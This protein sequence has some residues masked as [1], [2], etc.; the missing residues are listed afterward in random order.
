MQKV[1]E[2][3]ITMINTVIFILVQRKWETGEWCLGSPAGKVRGFGDPSKV[4]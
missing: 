4:R 1:L 3:V 2:I